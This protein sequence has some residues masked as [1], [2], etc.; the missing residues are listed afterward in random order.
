MKVSLQQGFDAVHFH[1][2]HFQR[3]DATWLKRWT[4]ALGKLHRSIW[5]QLQRRLWAVRDGDRKGGKRSFA[6]N[7]NL[8]GARFDCGRSAG[9]AICR[10]RCGASVRFEPEAAGSKSWLSLMQQTD[11]PDRS[12]NCA[13]RKAAV[14]C[15]HSEI[16][17]AYGRSAEILL[18]NSASGKKPRSFGTSFSGQAYG[19][20]RADQAI[21]TTRAWSRAVRERMRSTT[22]YVRSYHKSMRPDFETTRVL[23][24]FA[25]SVTAAKKLASP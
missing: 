18:K 10:P 3:I 23:T 17:R 4:S 6:A 21:D 5:L 13:A 22:A 2:R 9:G 15:C 16:W 25:R 1:G 7:A 14:R 11:C 8:I 20:E 24:T 12:K 19:R